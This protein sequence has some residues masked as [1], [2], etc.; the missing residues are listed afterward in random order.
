MVYISLTQF[1]QLKI[2]FNQSPK[3]ITQGSYT[4]RKGKANE[5]I[6]KVLQIIGRVVTYIHHTWFCTESMDS[7]VIFSYHLLI[8][9]IHLYA[10]N[11]Y[12]CLLSLHWLRHLPSLPG[13]TRKLTQMVFWYFHAPWFSTI[14]CSRFDAQIQCKIKL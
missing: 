13:T 5:T 3:I 10:E 2:G 14:W 11:G 8:G 4:K 12:T 9:C 1:T 6:L 7:E